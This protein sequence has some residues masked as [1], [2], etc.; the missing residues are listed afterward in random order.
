MS[1]RIIQTLALKHELTLELSMKMAHQC[2]VILH[3]KISN[4]NEF[5][6]FT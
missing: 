6:G 1:I 3:I 4:T 5:M 2:G